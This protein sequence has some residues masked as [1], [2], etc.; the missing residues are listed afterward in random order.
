MGLFKLYK[1]IFIDRNIS[2]RSP[3]LTQDVDRSRR[4]LFVNVSN[5]VIAI[6]SLFAVILIFSIVLLSCSTAISAESENNTTKFETMNNE[7]SAM[8]ID[9]TPEEI[10]QLIKNSKAKAT[11]V[12]V[13]ATWC[14]PCRE[15]FP[16]LVKLQADLR[17]KGFRL[18][19]IS[20]DF[21]RAVPEAKKFLEQQGVD[22]TT[23]RKVGKDMDFIN[24]LNPD[25]NGSLPGSFLY[26]EAGEQVY[27]WQG[28]ETY[29]EFKK[30]IL[31]L[32]EG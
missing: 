24:S 16:D 29:E 15:E 4:N 7:N 32:L 19:F 22:Y 31:P 20:A 1:K 30:H 6:Q 27:F 8:L 23:Y 2:N 5:P 13:W 9:V 25:W 18:I 12:N 11:L 10:T 17:D 21:D 28:K 14:M 3:D 26:N